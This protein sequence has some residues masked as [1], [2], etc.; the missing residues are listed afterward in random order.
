M[1][2]TVYGDFNLV[3]VDEVERLM[4]GDGS[5]RVIGNANKT[6]KDFPVIDYKVA[7]KDDLATEIMLI[8]SY[9]YG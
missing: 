1:K 9:Q 3:T 5:G 7:T 6:V 2:H 4:H 8:N